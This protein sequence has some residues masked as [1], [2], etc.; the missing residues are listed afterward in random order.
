MSQ[1]ASKTDLKRL[2]DGIVAAQGNV[3]IKEFLRDQGLRIGTTKADFVRN[4][5]RA[6]DDG[7]LRLF[8][9]DIH[10]YP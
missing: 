1:D 7:Q 3:F 6:I 2:A 4:L 8:I 9:D 10:R 5:H